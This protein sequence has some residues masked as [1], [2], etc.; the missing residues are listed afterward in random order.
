MRNNKKD[1]IQQKQDKLVA[2]SR[3]SVNAIDFVVNA[4]AGLL[5]INEEIDSNLEEIAT[6]KSELQKTEDELI[7]VKEKNKKISDKL[8]ALLAD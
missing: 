3:E 8:N 2:L 6:A 4:I 5:T 7:S 1:I